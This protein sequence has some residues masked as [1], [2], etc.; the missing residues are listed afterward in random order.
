MLRTVVDEFGDANSPLAEHH[1]LSVVH[2]VS[3]SKNHGATAGERWRPANT[4]QPG[5]SA[6][7]D[8]LRESLRRMAYAK[9]MGAIPE[10]RKFDYGLPCPELHEG[11]CK[12]AD[13]D[14][15]YHAKAVADEAF[16]YFDSCNTGMF[17]H[18]SALLS[19]QTLLSFWMVLGHSRFNNPRLNLVMGAE[20]ESETNE[21]VLNI[22]EDMDSSCSCQVFFARVF[23]EASGLDVD[24]AKIFISPAPCSSLV[25]LHKDIDRVCLADGWEST[26]MEMKHQLFPPIAKV[27]RAAM[28]QNSLLTQALKALQPKA[29]EG[30]C[31]TKVSNQDGKQRRAAALLRAA[32]ASSGNGDDGGAAAESSSD[33][34]DFPAD[35]DADDFDEEYFLH[36]HGNAGDAVDAAVDANVGGDAVDIPRTLQDRN[37]AWGPWSLSE[38]WSEGTQVGWRSRADHAAASP[39]TKLWRR[40]R[41]SEWLF[42]LTQSC[43]SRAA[44]TD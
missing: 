23:R 1:F 9:D 35:G 18:L 3:E 31:L 43:E 39:R 10:T 33:G 15:L 42:K 5:L 24:I 4:E 7:S 29:L 26:V 41:P 37:H 16:D 14:I 40:E 36:Q 28:A 38:V 25:G 30:R 17:W 32:A 2:G 22:V 8:V 19:D 6:Y 12:E 34:A 44:V 21:V 20:I 13:A 27:A 11:F